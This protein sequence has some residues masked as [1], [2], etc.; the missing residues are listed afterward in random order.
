MEIDASRIMTA[1]IA[2]KT[3]DEKVCFSLFEKIMKKVISLGPP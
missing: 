1:S 2:Q 3:E